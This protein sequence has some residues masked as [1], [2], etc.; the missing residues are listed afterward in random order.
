MTRE[1]FPRI[2]ELLDPKKDASDGFDFELNIR[3]ADT[4]FEQV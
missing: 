4:G 2:Y 1:R 3:I